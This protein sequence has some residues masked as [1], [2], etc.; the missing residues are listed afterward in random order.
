MVEEIKK[1]SK[2]SKIIVVGK[3]LLVGILHFLI[4]VPL[5]TSGIASKFP[6]PEFT[7][8]YLAIILAFVAYFAVI[9]QKSTSSKNIYLRIFIV[10]ILALGLTFISSWATLMGILTYASFHGG[11]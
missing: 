8:S 11:V 4:G 5:Y 3:L 2:K 7:E 9:F 6:F 1:D 10:F